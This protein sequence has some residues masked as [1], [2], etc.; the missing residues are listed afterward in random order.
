MIAAVDGGI[1]R[2]ERLGGKR[3]FSLQHGCERNNCGPFIRY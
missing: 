2:Y 1:G 3:E